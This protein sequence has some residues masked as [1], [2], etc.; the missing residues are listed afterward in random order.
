VATQIPEPTEPA[1]IAP[2][3]ALTTAQTLIFKGQINAYIKR[4]AIMH[5]NMQK[6]YSLSLGQCIE[7][8]KAK[9]KQSNE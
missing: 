1:I 9:L 8:L 7:L 2:A 4:E 5:E 3:T 6:A